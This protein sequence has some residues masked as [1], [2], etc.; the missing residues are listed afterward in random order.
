MRTT[1]NDLILLLVLHCHFHQTFWSPTVSAVV[2]THNAKKKLR[3]SHLDFKTVKYFCP[4]FWFSANSFKTLV[5]L[6]VVKFVWKSCKHKKF[7]QLLFFITEI[8]N[9]FSA[10]IHLYKK[11]VGKYHFKL[12]E[13]VPH[14][15]EMLDINLLHLSVS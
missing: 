11:V 2:V 3:E 10:V 5:L 15:D 1:S 8:S 9:S 7:L 13:M 12:N 6:I 4:F 14:R